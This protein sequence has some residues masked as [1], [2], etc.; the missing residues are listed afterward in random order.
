MKKLNRHAMMRKHKRNLKKKYGYGLYSGYRSNTKLHEEWCREKYGG[1]R[2]A[3]NGGYEYW[4]N[5]YLTG[6]RQ[7][8]K[9]CTNRVIRA[10]YR[11][12]INSLDADSLEDVQALTGS[13][14]EKMYDYNWTIW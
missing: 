14:Y 11:D 10:F 6:P 3:R 13:D 4:Q 7:Y 9:D 8:A 1:C 5:Y 12:L 2:N